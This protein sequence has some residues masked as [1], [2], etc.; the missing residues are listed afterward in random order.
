MAYRK[1]HI[2]KSEWQYTVGRSNVHI[3]GPNGESFNAPA[4]EISTPVV[5]YCSCGP[6]YN[7]YGYVGDGVTPASV[8][9]FIEAKIK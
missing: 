3:K 6:E 9:K 2:N 4:E 8:K 5:H 1:I 7:C